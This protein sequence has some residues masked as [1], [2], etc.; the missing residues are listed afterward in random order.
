MEIDIG[1]EAIDRGFATGYGGY[2][3]IMAEN[4]ANAT[5][6]IDTVE[7]WCNTDLTGVRVGTFY[8]TNG[9]T[10]KCRDSAV[11]G[12]VTSGSMQTITEDSGSNPLAIAVEVDDYIGMFYDTGNVERDASGSGFWRVE[13]ENIDPNDEAVYD[14]VADQTISLK[15]IGAEPGWTGKVSGVTNPAKIMGV[16]VAN[17]AKVKGVA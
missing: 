16:P 13:A 12:N 17:I 1:P 10:L 15:G 11:I 14:W 8:T 5:G 2:T 6:I 9:N 4:P 7:I 3:V